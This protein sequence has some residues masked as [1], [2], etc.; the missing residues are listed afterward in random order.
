M[1]WIRIISQFLF[2]GGIIFLL[3]FTNTRYSNNT[4]VDYR[5]NLADENT[6]LITRGEI[7][8]LME[9]INDSIV[10]TTIAEVPIYEIERKIESLN[11][12]QNAEVYINM[13]GMLHID[14]IQK[15][16]IVRVS[17]KIG[18][19]FYMDA[20]GSI[21]ALSNNYTKHLLVA[22]GNIQDTAD[23]IAVLNLAKQISSDSLW[24]SQIMQIYIKENKE[25]EL[26]PRVGNHKILFGDISDVEEKLRRLYLFYKKG[27]NQVG[28]N[29][30]EEINLKFKN[31]IVCVKR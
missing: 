11:D 2:L 6:S 7:I 20:Q 23:Y 30:Y 24:S 1:K 3:A 27:V 26:I 16:A 31:Q 13:E 8:L 25:I 21:F 10:G 19:D 22:S 4:C 29:D 5:I 17:P 12:V 9:S 18:N 14:V 28:W 15:K